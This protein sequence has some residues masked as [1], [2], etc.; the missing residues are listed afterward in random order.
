MADLQNDATLH[1]PC[2]T[3]E[4]RAALRPKLAPQVG[5]KEHA[6]DLVLAEGEAQAF[7]MRETRVTGHLVLDDQ[8]RLD[9]AGNLKV[10]GNVVAV[11]FDDTLLFV[12]GT[13]EAKT[14]L[15]SGELVAL[16]EIQVQGLGADLLQRRLDLHRSS[17][18]ANSGP[19]RPL[20]VRRRG[21]CGGL[22]SGPAK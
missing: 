7:E 19:G 20:R 15:G 22:A 14:L 2:E 12:G 8:S 9:V 11:N 18:G 16:G 6:G 4:T 21:A 5:R 1:H 17:E 10:D 3:A 13:L